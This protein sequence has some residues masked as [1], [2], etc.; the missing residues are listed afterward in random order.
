MDAST[1]PSCQKLKIHYGKTDNSKSKCPPLR[2][3]GIKIGQFNNYLHYIIFTK[4]I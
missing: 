4:N 3:G 1:L 2:V